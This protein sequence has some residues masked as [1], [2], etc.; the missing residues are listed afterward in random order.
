MTEHLQDNRHCLATMCLPASGTHDD[1]FT[2]AHVFIHPCP[3]FLHPRPCQHVLEHLRFPAAMLP[4][5]IYPGI[6][7]IC[8]PCGAWRLA[9]SGTGPSVLRSPVHAPVLSSAAR[10]RSA[11][12]RYTV[13][14]WCV[15][16]GLHWVCLWI[17]L[18][19]LFVS[20][21]ATCVDIHPG[22]STFYS[23]E[24]QT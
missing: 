19:P 21:A 13:T 14:E 7:C 2:T 1:A 15:C 12:I 4:L 8:S 18:I 24:C 3:H 6:G 22:M 5:H 9:A 20:F 16:R 11:F 10:E 17:S 23:A